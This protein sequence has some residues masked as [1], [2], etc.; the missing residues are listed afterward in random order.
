M[1]VRIRKLGINDKDKRALSLSEDDFR[2]YR[3]SAEWSSPRNAHLK[4]IFNQ[5]NNGFEHLNLAAMLL[6]DTKIINAPD[7]ANFGPEEETKYLGMLCD[8]LSLT[9]DYILKEKDL[10][11]DPDR[12][13]M[14]HETTRIVLAAS[15]I[16]IDIQAQQMVRPLIGSA[17]ELRR[18]KTD[19]PEEQ[20]GAALDQPM[21]DYL[22]LRGGLQASLVW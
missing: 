16:M 12:I 3:V 2:C 17:A 7:F 19:T 18:L 13:G 6:I 9:K 1:P 10:S 5:R 20:L 22:E 11:L 4:V 8:K 15:P 21:R 14:R